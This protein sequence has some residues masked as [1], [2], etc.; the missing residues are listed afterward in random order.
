V[1]DPDGRLARGEAEWLERR[2]ALAMERLG[3]SGEVRVRVVGEA[4]MA[5]LHG[6]HAG[7]AASTDV[8]TFDLSDGPGAPLDADIV[9]SAD[10]AAREASLR[11]HAVEREVLLYVVH[12]M[13]H[14]LGHDD[15]DER[16]AQAMHALE[17]EVLEAIGV[18][19]TFGAPARR[20]GAEA[21]T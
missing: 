2:G 4:E 8:L 9:V 13:L 3:A 19:A 6:R 15:H 12:G 11:G 16:G 14:C 20:P 5:R 21:G 7:E 10:E 18:G 1:A 17:D